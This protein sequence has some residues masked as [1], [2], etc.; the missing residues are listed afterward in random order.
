MHKMY[1]ASG[2][3]LVNISDGCVGCFLVQ[4]TNASVIPVRIKFSFNKADYKKVTSDI[5]H[6]YTVN[7]V[8]HHA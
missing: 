1:I 5:N 6:A 8:G 7:G 3:M 2:T 4:L